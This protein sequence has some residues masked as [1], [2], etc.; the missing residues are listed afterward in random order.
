MYSK[1]FNLR[2]LLEMLCLTD[3]TFAFAVHLFSLT[4]V[5]LLLFIKTQVTAD[6][7]NALHLNQRRHWTLSDM[8]CCT[9]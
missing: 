1:H 9:L 3:D 6:A 7:P 5:V 8:S 2:R 4:T